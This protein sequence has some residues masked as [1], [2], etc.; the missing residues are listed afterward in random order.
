MLFDI[1]GKRPL[2]AYNKFMQEEL[3]RMKA[4]NQSLDHK[5]AFKAAA[6]NV[7]PRCSCTLD[8]SP[9]ADTHSQ[10]QKHKE[11]QK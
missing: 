5:A 4:A 11:S 1:G 2:T 7:R 6:A 9:N 10:W 8:R 3:A